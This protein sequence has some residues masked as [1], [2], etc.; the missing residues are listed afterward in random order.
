MK[1]LALSLLVFLCLGTQ[2]LLGQEHHSTMN[3]QNVYTVVKPPSL[4]AD[5]SILHTTA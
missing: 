4:Y 3:T 1:Y 5:R 2:R